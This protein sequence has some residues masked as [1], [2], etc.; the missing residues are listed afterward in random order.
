[1]SVWNK[2][3]MH[4]GTSWIPLDFPV[5][6]GNDRVIEVETL[7]GRTSDAVFHDGLWWTGDMSDIIDDGIYAW[8]EK[9]TAFTRP[10]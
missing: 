10:K 1:M 8:R 3:Y 5:V 9:Y 2:L 4:D 6:P 7:Y